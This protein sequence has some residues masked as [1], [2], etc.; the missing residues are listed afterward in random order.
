[1]PLP[2]TVYLHQTDAVSRGT[3]LQVSHYV[4]E[5]LTISPAAG[6]L[7]IID[8]AFAVRALGPEDPM[9]MCLWF[10]VRHPLLANRNYR[11]AVVLHGE[12][13]EPVEVLRTRIVNASNPLQP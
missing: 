2:F 13:R 1:M 6:Q 11:A 7:D 12:D 5:I 10:R 3:M 8:R 9:P 4:D